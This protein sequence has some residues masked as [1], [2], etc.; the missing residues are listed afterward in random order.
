MVRRAR[1]W[2]ADHPDAP[3]AV[4]RIVIEQLADL[5]RGLRAQAVS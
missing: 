2:L 1:Q 4:R 3:D 5:E